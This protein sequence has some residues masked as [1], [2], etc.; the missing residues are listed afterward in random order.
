M[1]QPTVSSY[2]YCIVDMILALLTFEYGH[3]SAYHVRG[4][5]I[6]SPVEGWRPD[7]SAHKTIVVPNQH[8][9]QTREKTDREE[10]GSAPEFRH[11]VG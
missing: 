4:W 2:Y 8:E 11:I 7:Q 3:D 1:K 9:S 5:V 10:E 6:K